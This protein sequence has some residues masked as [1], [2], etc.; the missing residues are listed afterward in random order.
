MSQE[1]Q[2]GRESSLSRHLRKVDQFGQD[3]RLTYNG[4][5]KYTTVTGGICTVTIFCFLCIFT[6]WAIEEVGDDLIGFMSVE[7][8][9]FTE[10][11]SDNYGNLERYEPY[12]ETNFIE[13][14]GMI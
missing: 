1:S 9:Q 12:T 7:M 4:R 2:V 10:P 8:N 6:I 3:I 13:G 11:F 5:D 14:F